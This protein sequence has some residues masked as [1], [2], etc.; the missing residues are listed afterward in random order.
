MDSEVVSKE[1]H[2]PNTTENQPENDLYDQGFVNQVIDV[3]QSWKVV[4]LTPD[5][6]VREAGH[7]ISEHDEQQVLGGY[8][9]DGDGRHS[10]N[11][12]HP[13]EST[14][15][16]YTPETKEGSLQRPVQRVLDNL[17]YSH[18]Q[19]LFSR[20][21]AIQ[22]QRAVQYHS[23]V[24]K[25]QL[26]T[27]GQ[28]Q[29]SAERE[30]AASKDDEKMNYVLPPYLREAIAQTF[31]AVQESTENVVNSSGDLGTRQGHTEES[32]QLQKETTYKGEKL[33]GSDTLNEDQPKITSEK[34]CISETVNCEETFLTDEGNASLEGSLDTS[35]VS[36]VAES[37]PQEVRAQ[38]TKA[39]VRACHEALAANSF[40]HITGKLNFSIDDQMLLQMKVNQRV[41]TL[42]GKF[43]GQTYQ[44][45]KVCH[46]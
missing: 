3:Q 9:V 36:V 31:R 24:P 10:H 4:P 28:G 14:R 46:F 43:E 13:E 30:M 23:C 2:P 15:Y 37:V 39:L 18:Q 34:E 16:A 7:D 8:N 38:V 19:Q 17:D 26:I 6:K 5:S 22:R 11:D 29:P 27:A 32:T 20:P 21:P 25:F 12:P 33:A 40:V 42:Q 45:N 1:T 44:E 35:E 41:D